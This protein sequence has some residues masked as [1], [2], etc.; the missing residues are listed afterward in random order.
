M[1]K[2]INPSDWPDN[3]F[4]E[5]LHPEEHYIYPQ[6][7]D[8]LDAAIDRLEEREKNFVVGRY[9]DGK[10]LDTLASE[11]G[12]TRERIRQIVAK[13]IRKLS[14]SRN[15][16]TIFG[17]YGTERGL[18]KLK[19][20]IMFQKEMLD[21]YRQKLISGAYKD[22]PLVYGTGMRIE[23]MGFSVRTYNCLTRAGVYYLDDLLAAMVKDPDFL[24]KV[25]NLGIKS[26]DEVR[27]KL[28]FYASRT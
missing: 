21:A 24:S 22:L 2:R 14:S 8:G 1:A 28:S 20:D 12:L 4:D 26:A 11:Y 5:I 6:S 9:R 27:D 10:T 23:D 25:R 7:L 16:K 19:K 17:E 3:L 13:A 18:L 15:I